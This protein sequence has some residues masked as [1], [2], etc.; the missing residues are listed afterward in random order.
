MNP[1]IIS[2]PTYVDEFI[3]GIIAIATFCN[4]TCNNLFLLLYLFEVNILFRFIGFAILLIL[5]L[6]LVLLIFTPYPASA[7]IKK[8]FEGGVAVEPENYAEIKAN[9]VQQEHIIYKS[10]FSSNELDVISPK[11]VDTP[12]PVILWVHGGAF[13]AGDKSDITEYAVQIAEKGY[14]VVNINYD[15]AP[16]AKYPTPLLQLND[17]YQ[18]VM[19]NAE[20]YKFDITKLLFAGDSA[21]AQIVSQYALIQTNEAYAKEIQITP[22]VAKENIAGLLLFCGPFDIQKLSHLSDNK[23]VAFLLNRVGW[24]YIGD[25]TWQ[26]SETARLAS[27]ID[28]VTFDYPPSFITDGNVMT[29]DEHGKELAARLQELGVPVVEKFYEGNE[30]PHEY[31]FMMNTPEA[32]ETFD[33]V[34]KFIGEVVE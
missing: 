11:T 4:S 28:F 5:V 8:L 29:F 26:T 30:L 15:L 34:V 22:V 2:S 31:Q 3:I 7:V 14:H 12:L 18:W 20:S 13:V 9:T 17:V 27:P 1:K 32:F 33:A 16:K 10:S 6:S 23:I 24:G 25:R 21:G 19:E